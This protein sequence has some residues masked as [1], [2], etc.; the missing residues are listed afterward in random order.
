MGNL[1]LDIEEL[2]IYEGFSAAIDVYGSSRENA[3]EN[4]RSLFDQLA[5]ATP[6]RL[7]LGFDENDSPIIERPE[8]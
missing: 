4:A 6:W 2:D 8:L 1:V 7:A 5:G 3:K